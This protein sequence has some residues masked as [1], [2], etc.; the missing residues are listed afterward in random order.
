MLKEEIM[1]LVSRWANEI[2]VKASAAAIDELCAPDFVFHYPGITTKPDRDGFKE[3]T[4]SW[5]TP[6]ADIQITIED[7]LIAGDKVTVR[8]LW[9]GKHTGDYMGIAPTGKNITMT[10]ISIIQIAGG[11]IVEEWGEMDNLGMMSQL[12]AFSA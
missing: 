11:K 2:W 1:A 4:A 8:W 5:L 12:G 10:G 6:F 7:T 9:R 3:T